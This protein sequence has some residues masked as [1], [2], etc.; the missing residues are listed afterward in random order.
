MGAL[1]VLRFLVAVP[2]VAVTAGVAVFSLVELSGGTPFSLG[3]LRNVAEAAGMGNGAEILR[4]LRAGDDP[5]RVWPV[6]PE[7][8]SSSVTQATALEAAVWSRRR[9]IIDLLNRQG[10]LADPEV[11]RQVYCLASDLDVDEIKE[12]FSPAPVPA[13]EAGQTLARV[14]ERTRRP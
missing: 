4:L 13:C 3:P 2:L 14:L 1:K 7:I 9:E 8:I 6:R 5:Q 12:Y 11:R 10:A